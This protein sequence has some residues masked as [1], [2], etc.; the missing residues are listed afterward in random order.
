[1]HILRT[2]IPIFVIIA[3]GWV[4]RRTDFMPPEFL[5]TG[6]PGRSTTSPSRP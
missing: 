1:M 3:M 2:I 4:A 5:G 6:Q